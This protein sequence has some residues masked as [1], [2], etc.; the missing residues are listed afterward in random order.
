VVAGWYAHHRRHRVTQH[1]AR[2][3]WLSPLEQLAIAVV[4]NTTTITA[5][6]D[7]LARFTIE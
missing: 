5:N 7:R 4:R 1:S 6:N 2:V 3:D